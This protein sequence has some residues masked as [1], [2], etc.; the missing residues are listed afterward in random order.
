[1]RTRGSPY[2]Q[3]DWRDVLAK[4]RGSQARLWSYGISHRTLTIRLESE[5]RE[6]NL[7]IETNDTHVIQMP[8]VWFNAN[9]EIYWDV[10]YDRFKDPMSLLID[11]T[12]G[13]RILAT[14]ICFR[15]NVEPLMKVI[16]P[17]DHAPV[18]DHYMKVW[19]EYTV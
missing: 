2:P 4:W 6:G 15:E 5:N 9:I 11:K 12:A 3:T 16:Y 18:L 13:V 8:T 1:M 19:T 7:H 17:K 10:A 14:G